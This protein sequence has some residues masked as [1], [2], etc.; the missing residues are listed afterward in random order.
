MLSQRVSPTLAALCLWAASG[1]LA[2]A[3]VVNVWLTTNDQQALMAP[4][5]SVSFTPGTGQLPSIFISE[6]QAEQTIEGFGASM[7]DSAAYLLNGVVPRA[8]LDGVMQSIFGRSQGIGVSFLRNPMGAS[9]ITRPPDYSYDDTLADSTDSS[10]PNFSVFHDQ[11]DILPLLLQAKAINPQIKMLGTP[12]SPPGWMKENSSMVGGTSANAQLLPA[13]YT[14]FANYLVKYVQAYQAAGVPVDYLTIQNEPLN[15]PTNY[16]GEYMAGTDQLN[17]LKN[18]V[19]PALAAA[20]IT[21]KILVYDHNWD[22][23]SYPETV[24]ADPALAASPQIA[25]VA[26]HWYGGPPGAM[27]T[28]HNLYPQ[29]GQYITEASGETSIPD[30]EQK[31]FE[32][33]IHS[34]RNWSRSYVKWSLA[35]DQNNGPHTGGCGDCTG[36]IMVNS[37]TGAVTNNIDYYTLGHFSKFVLPGAVRV[38]SNNAPGLISAAFINPLHRVGLAGVAHSDARE[39]SRVLVVYNDSASTRTFQVVWYG[40]SFQYSLPSY[41]GATFQW[42]AGLE[43]SCRGGCWTPVISATT[44]IQASSYNELSGLQTEPCTD[45]DSNGGFDLGY[46]APGLWA[47]YRNIDFGSGVSSV[48]VRVANDSGSQGTL[49]FHSGSPTGPL[50]AQATI[51]NTG[52]WQTWTTVTAPVSGASGVQN[53][54]LVFQSGSS[55]GEGNVNWFQFQ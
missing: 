8:A 27:T 55:S 50:L 47:E 13:Q 28:L 18:Y 43:Y 14:A 3:Q 49:E 36:L 30:E 54:F 4:Q 48:Q 7:T 52:A 41:A 6:S 31:D 22:T 44:Q 16:P 9:D 33:I 19:L 1:T 51:P 25:G 46:S 45:T 32:M 15:V 11:A 2:S 38:W 23:P 21:T 53:L 20:N 29:L 26:W 17:I 12:W 42:D 10:L 24:L 5:P 40:T 37:N 39:R 35:L 34:M